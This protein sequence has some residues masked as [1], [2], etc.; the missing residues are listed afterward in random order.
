MRVALEVWDYL[1]RMCMRL[2]IGKGMREPSVERE[3][4][5]TAVVC[6]GSLPVRDPG[7]RN[8]PRAHGKRQ[9][10]ENRL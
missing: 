1:W 8:A 3:T 9:V 2:Y 6:I 4:E 10:I 7:P 5:S